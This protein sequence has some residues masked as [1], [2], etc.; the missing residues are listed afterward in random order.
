MFEATFESRKVYAD[1]FND[2]D[3][4]VIFT[5]Q[6]QSWRV[7]AFWRGE[8]KWTVR[9]APPSPGEY[10]YRLESTDAK[11]TDLNGH[12]GTVSI[13]AYAGR[14]SL[15]IHGPL[16]VSGNG[17]YFEH[18][19][20]TPFFWL[21]ETL[22]TALSD[23][24]SWEGFQ[25]LISDR[26]TKGFTVAQ[27][28]AGLTCSNE[29][30]APVDYGFR[31]EG[32]PVWDP[33]FQRINP[34]YFDYADR[35]VQYLVD[36]GITPAIIG[37]WNQSLRQ[38]G[39]AKMEK[40][41]RYIIAR[42]GA[43]PV[44]WILGGEIY[45]PPK[46]VTQARESTGMPPTPGWTE[47]A[48]Y[49]RATDP[50]HRLLTAHEPPLPYDTPLQDDSLTD[51]KLLQPSHFGWASVALEV[52]QLNANWARTDR[53]KPLVVG[54]VGWEKIGAEHLENLQRTA[55]WLAL[56]NGAAGFSY[57]ATETSLAYDTDKP[58]HRIRYSFRTW[59]EAMN[60]PGA[61]QAGIAKKLLEQYPWWRFEPHP[62]WVTP[63]GTTLLEARIGEPD[64]GDWAPLLARANS[65]VPYRD[66]GFPAGEWKDRH[67]D[68]F[69][70]YAA[71]ITNMVRIIYLPYFG[72]LNTW[73][74]PPTILG[75]EPGVTYHAYYWEP[76]LGIKV[77]LGLVEHP[78]PGAL[79][80]AD[81]FESDRR[82]L[83]VEYGRKSVHAGRLAV[84]GQTIAIL[85]D[86]SETDC[87]LAVDAL[88]GADA[89][90][91]VRYRDPKNYVAA[92]YSAKEKS[93]YLI[94]RTNG[95]DGQELG[96]TSVPFVESAMRLAV[97]VR[98]EVGVV[99]MT[100]G[101]RTYI[102]PIVNVGQS[103][104]GGV[105]L[106]HRGKGGA[107]SFGNFELHKNPV[108]T[109]DEHLEK[110]LYDAD[111]GYRGE[112]V[113]PGFPD[114]P[115]RSGWDSYGKNK[116]ILLGAYRPERLPFAGDWVLVLA[117]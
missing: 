20:G 15:L 113:G 109:I 22:Y 69:L 87:V 5:K 24:I 4:D 58:F 117:H 45:D 103:V 17:R 75:L 115:Q 74:D 40:H 6:G 33:A 57:G 7:P 29:E 68:I 77:D 91:V 56:L 65:T 88:S 66:L 94:S 52:A 102:T 60:Y 47:V 34:R 55:F 42:Y 89:G 116:N 78:P 72:F 28:A 30:L 16:H 10:T 53:R 11:S 31:N 105:G 114:S 81:Q 41:W 23:R 101:K 50:Y 21:G 90:L 93:I 67:G 95:M 80:E 9:F 54:E 98:N 49:I 18:S 76:S 59:E 99:S 32:G 61:Y 26:I 82:W 73:T 110:K 62:E 1:P 71:G 12:E 104:A 51:F 2:V 107:Q 84:E 97:E 37:A 63:R 46:G 43:Y 13:T 70:P 44:L 86:S 14:N 38:M 108:L 106:M 27:I 85:R 79:I 92:R 100:D 39:V 48:R 36:G 3:V 25:K 64:L 96:R 111:G 8:S 112:L 35:R 83:W 19:D